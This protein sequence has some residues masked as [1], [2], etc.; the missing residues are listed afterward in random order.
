MLSLNIWLEE[1]Y[2]ITNTREIFLD[3]VRHYSHVDICG[4]YL[5]AERCFC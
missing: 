2:G 3:E 5:H 1:P 4:N